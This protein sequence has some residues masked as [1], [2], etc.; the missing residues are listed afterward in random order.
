MLPQ[1]ALSVGVKCV[2]HVACFIALYLPWQ[3]GASLNNPCSHFKMCILDQDITNSP[4][5]FSIT[6]CLASTL[7]TI[8]LRFISQVIIRHVSS[9]NTS[10]NFHNNDSKPEPTGEDSVQMSKCNILI[11]VF[12]NKKE[13]NSKF[14]ALTTVHI[15]IF[16]NNKVN[17]MQNKHRE[18]TKLYN[19]VML[20]FLT[21]EH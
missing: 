6:K 18:E 15:N 14:L 2:F 12:Y 5:S 10:T 13:D 9:C 8:Q 3:H 20:N 11:V 21:T 1:A 19:K 17:L 7:V 4:S 16:L